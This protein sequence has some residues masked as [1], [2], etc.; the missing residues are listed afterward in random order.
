MKTLGRLS[1]WL[2]DSRLDD[3]AEIY[4]RQFSPLLEAHGLIDAG[5]DCRPAV[6]G[7]FRRLFALEQPAEIQVKEGVLAKD[8]AWQDALW[9]AE[10][11][12]GLK[13]GIKSCFE[14]YRAPAGPGRVM[15]VGL[16]S[17]RELWQ[18]F[19]IL[20]GMPSCIAHLLQDKNG[21]LWMGTGWFKEGGEWGACRFDGAQLL[22]LTVADGLVHDRVRV[23]VEDQRGRLW[24]GT[25]GGIC[26]YDGTAFESYTEADG[27]GS[28]A[29]WSLIADD[30]GYLWAGTWDG[31]SRW[32]GQCFK[33]YGAAEGLPSFYNPGDGHHRIGVSSLLKDR[34]GQL[35]A[36]TWNGLC[37]WNGR[38]FETYTTADG[39]TN[40]WV[41]CLLEDEQGD[42]WVGTG[43]WDSG[44]G[45]RQ[46]ARRTECLGWQ[47]L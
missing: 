21:D 22:R 28:N 43:V 19:G 27:L 17:R 41:R 45:Q 39:L 24:F 30:S 4:G 3:F 16:G 35:W 14:P 42:I 8:K 2:P 15:R 46:T 9:T 11:R 32:D 13:D 34:R 33:N 1:F 26:C 29:V 7:V 40:D 5:A 23:L 6:K 38:R 36:G 47:R 12:L 37:R 10:N 25:Y 31:L 44:S 20:D 18:S